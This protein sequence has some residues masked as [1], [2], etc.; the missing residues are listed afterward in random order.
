MALGA[1][2]A[3]LRL[4]QHEPALRAAELTVDA[5]CGVW[6]TS[7]WDGLEVSLRRATTLEADAFGRARFAHALVHSECSPTAAGI[8]PLLARN[9]PQTEATGA[10]K[11]T[12]ATPPYAW[13][14]AAAERAWPFAKLAADAAEMGC[15]NRTETRRPAL[16][17]RLGAEADATSCAAG[18]P[19]LQ[20][21]DVPLFVRWEEYVPKYLA[22]AKHVRFVQIGAN[23]GRNARSCAVGG[24]P[25]W[26]YVQSC[27]W[28]GLAFEPVPG[29]FQKLCRNIA[30][31]GGQVRALRAV[32]SNETG[33]AWV[34]IS[35]RN[36]G[37]R[38]HVVPTPAGGIGPS[39]LVQRIPS[40][41]LEDVWSPEGVDVLIVDAE[42]SE[43]RILGYGALPT[44]LPRLVLFEHVYLSEAQRAR[45][46]ANLLSQGF[47]RVADLR[48]MDARGANNPP[49]DRLYGRLRIT[50]AGPSGSG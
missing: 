10:W 46:D 23:C 50:P 7:G 22:S 5:L 18:P 36:G 37:E 6:R 16:Q 40:L 1:L 3:A 19:P 20:A 38:S 26:N 13:T 47:E 31:I 30:A 49:Q 25:V 2:L 44:P 34:K 17:P 33:S 42:G 41:S 21:G 43:E 24:D 12:V 48:H 9:R 39:S 35:A 28:R 11:Q 8:L 4:E 27:G 32:V 15:Q 14:W 45:I 29:T